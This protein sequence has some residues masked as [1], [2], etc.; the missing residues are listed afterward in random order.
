MSWVQAPRDLGSSTVFKNAKTLIHHDAEWS[1]ST[2][3]LRLYLFK[4]QTP[5]GAILVEWASSF[6]GSEEVVRIANFAFFFY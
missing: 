5:K 3:I 4:K 2:V 6:H 1:A